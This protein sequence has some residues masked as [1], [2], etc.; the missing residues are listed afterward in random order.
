MSVTSASLAPYRRSASATVP[1]T[2]QNMSSGCSVGVPVASL[3]RYR[4]LIT[5]RALSFNWASPLGGTAGMGISTTLRGKEREVNKR[6]TGSALHACASGGF[7][8]G[9]D[10]I[11]IRES[12]PAF[13][14]PLSSH[15]VTLSTSRNDG[16]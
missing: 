9:R 4:L 11:G 6:T 10:S 7:D 8:A 13:S 1:A 14:Y 2:R 12:A 3:I 16:S 15:R 5:V